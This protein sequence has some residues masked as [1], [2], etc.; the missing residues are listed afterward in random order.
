MNLPPGPLLQLA[1]DTHDIAVARRLVQDV[2]PH[3]DILEVGTPLVLAEGLRAIETLRED[4]SDKLI[5][6][7]LKIMDAGEPEAEIAFRHGADI[8]TVLALA[9]DQTIRGV[10]AAAKRY[11]RQIMAD[12]INT[13]DLIDRAVYLESLGVHIFCIHTALDLLG[14]GVDPLK[15]LASLRK[16]VRGCIAVAG[17]LQLENLEQA[18]EQGA[19]ILIVGGGIT[20]SLSP[21]ETGARYAQ[22]IHEATTCNRSL[23]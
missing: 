7:D 11:S 12:L 20:A 13:P 23:A 10:L 1:L 2:Y 19:D 14:Q 3:F 16:A 8:T 18:I 15:Q 21:G 6:A 4:C 9:D 5:L 17:G 22:Q